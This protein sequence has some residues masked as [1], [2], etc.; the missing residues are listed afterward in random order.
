MDAALTV[1]T[2][3]FFA[4]RN[5]VFKI[6]ARLTSIILKPPISIGGLDTTHLQHISSIQN[7]PFRRVDVMF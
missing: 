6:D 5:L 2:L 7:I 3:D 1:Q 4:V